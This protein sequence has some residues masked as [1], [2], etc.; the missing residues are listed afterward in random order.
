VAKGGVG[1]KDGKGHRKTI[2]GPTRIELANVGNLLS[3]ERGRR[4]VLSL[5]RCVRSDA[6][7]WIVI[8]KET[9]SAQERS[10]C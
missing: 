3:I 6:E 7:A 2:S 4:R 1:S 8:S 5:T 9:T 10:R